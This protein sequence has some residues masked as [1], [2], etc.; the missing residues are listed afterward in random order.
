M[1]LLCVIFINF[2]Q[3]PLLFQINFDS[4]SHTWYCIYIPSKYTKVSR[5]SDYLIQLEAVE[6]DIKD[7]YN[8]DLI[9]VELVEQDK[10]THDGL[11]KITLL[12]YLL[13]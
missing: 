4:I 9:N 8:S 11:T 13:S 5:R 10:E 1:C 7:K 3:K 6:I 12:A 2:V